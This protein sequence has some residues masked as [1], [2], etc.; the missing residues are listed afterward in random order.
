MLDKPRPKEDV[1]AVGVV[2]PGT[3]DVVAG[4]VVFADDDG[5][6]KIDEPVVRLIGA[7]EALELEIAENTGVFEAVNDESALL[8]LRENIGGVAGGDV[9]VDETVD[10][11]EETAE[12]DNVV[13]AVVGLV[14]AEDAGTDWETVVEEV[15]GGGETTV[16]E[17][18][19][20][21][22][23]AEAGVNVFPKVN[24]DGGLAEEIGALVVVLFAGEGV[25]EKIGGLLLV[26]KE[27]DVGAENENGV[28]LVV[29][30]VVVVV[31]RMEVAVLL[32]V[33]AT[34][35]VVVEVASVEL[36][37]MDAAP[38]DADIEELKVNA[39]K[40]VEGLEND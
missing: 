12:L 34:M 22:G 26:V 6:E 14:D 25:E 3:E 8:V 27:N 29:A 37:D 33:G 19:S 21:A 39:G 32:G 11:V 36:E 35:E 9:A 1:V 40:A 16:D 20:V 38:G 17:T 24:V 7:S 10:M 5:G 4:A 2:G 30:V 15:V 28:A 31:V 13:A 23:E 18:A